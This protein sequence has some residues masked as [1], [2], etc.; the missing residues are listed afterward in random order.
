MPPPDLARDAPVADVFHPVIVGILPLFRQDA[1]LSL[2]HRLKCALGQGADLDVPLERQ[3]RFNHG[4]AAVA[5]A[6]RHGV[7]LDSVQ[8]ACLLQVGHDAFAGSEAVH[9]LVLVACGVDDPRFVEDI[10][11][12]QS[13]AQAD[14]EVVEVVGRGDLDHTGSEL[15]VNVVVGHHRDLA[16]DQRQEHL[17]AHQVGVAFVLGM[18]RHRR[19]P[20]HGFRAGGGHDDEASRLTHHRVADVP[21]VPFLLLV[22]HLDVGQSGVATGA[23][24]DQAVVAIDQAVLVQ[25]DEHRAHRRGE[26]FVHGE[27]LPLPVTG[28]AQAFQLADDLSA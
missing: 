2:L 7:V 3:V 14:L 8:E 10:D 12:V 20:Q 16:V 11:L 18:H 9:P 6:H 17:L 15:A 19:V 1:G 25:L 13:V 21:E 28:G 4:L 22:F 26:A 5:A 24:V 27:A 23:P